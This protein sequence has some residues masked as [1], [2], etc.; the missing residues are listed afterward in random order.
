MEAPPIPASLISAFVA[1]GR[2]HI[3]RD[4]R[5]G[6]DVPN[7]YSACGSLEHIMSSCTAS[8]DALWNK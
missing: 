2:G 3:G 7:K 4:R 5:G 6:R 8:D 1:A